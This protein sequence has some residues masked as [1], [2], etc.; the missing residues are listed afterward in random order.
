[1]TLLE[2]LNLEKYQSDSSKSTYIKPY[3]RGN[4]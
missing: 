3:L 2:E 1:M 4:F